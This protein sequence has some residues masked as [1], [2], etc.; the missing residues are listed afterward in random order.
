[1]NKIIGV[2]EDGCGEVRIYDNLAAALAD[3]EVTGTIL[4]APHEIPDYYR[5]HELA[6]VFRDLGEDDLASLC[7]SVGQQFCVRRLQKRALEDRAKTMWEALLKAEGRR[8]LMSEKGKDKNE[9]AGRPSKYPDEAKI[10]L[11]ADK[12]GNTYGPKHNPKRAGSASAERFALYKDGMTVKKYVENGGSRA[13]L[14]WDEHRNFI[15]VEQ[16]ATAA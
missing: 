4:T 15:K 5:P 16:P 3:E 10:R 11:L 13:D 2:T 14:A 8:L 9:S 1:M 7:S 6:V 12:D